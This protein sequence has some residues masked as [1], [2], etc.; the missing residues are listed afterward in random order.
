[1]TE[2]PITMLDPQVFIENS[3]FILKVALVT[4]TASLLFFAPRETESLQMGAEDSQHVVVSFSLEVCS[5]VVFVL[6]V[7]LLAAWDLVLALLTCLFAVGCIIILTPQSP[8]RKQPQWERLPVKTNVAADRTE[9]DMATDVDTAMLE[10][11]LLAP[12][13]RY[14]DRQPLAFTMGVRSYSTV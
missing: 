3:S 13:R 4:A 8:P 5:G 6:L 12:R 1:M 14:V 10:Y 7:T 11:A 2:R 9:T